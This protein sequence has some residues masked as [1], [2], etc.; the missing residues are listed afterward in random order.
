MI[1]IAYIYLAFL[2]LRI[3]ILLSNLLWRPYLKNGGYFGNKT[4]SILIPARNEASNLPLLL[5]KLLAQTYKPLEIIVYDDDSDDGTWEV[6]Q[7][8]SSLSKV[9]RPIKGG[10]LPEGWLGKNHACYQLSKHALGDYLLFLDADVR[11]HAVLIEKALA[12]VEINKLKLL[13]LFPAQDM[14]SLGEKITIP[15]MQNILL[16]LLSL[17]LVQKS[18]K[19]SLA[20]ANGQF[21]FFDAAVYKKIQPHAWVKNHPAEDIRIIRLYKKF[22]FKVTTLLG[23]QTI[24]CRMYHGYQESLNGFSKNFLSFFGESPIFLF[25]FLFFTTFGWLFL[26]WLSPTQLFIGLLAI[27]LLNLLQIIVAGRNFVHLILAPVQQINAWIIAIYA[28]FQSN[29][30]SITWKKRIIHH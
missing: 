4:V 28:L 11:P 8:F 16:S 12:Y 27:I 19:P 15:V 26:F 13:S 6:L 7:S 17:P 18:Q 1:I 10:P 25:F 24:N 20:A 22:H 23:N 9:I 2:G 5:G 30:K 3:L 21:M 14:V 29:N